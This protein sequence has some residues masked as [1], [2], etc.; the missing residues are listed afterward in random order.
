MPTSNPRISITLAPAD[1]AVLDRFAAASGTPRA[2]VLSGLVGSVLPQLQEAAELIELANAAPKRVHDELAESLSEA[3]RDAM[4]Y[5]KDFHGTYKR[6]MAIVQA[7]E[8]A[9]GRKER[10]APGPAV[11]PG[12]RP[13]P[14][15]RGVKK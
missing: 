12:S 5:L 1:L 10:A 4:G 15:N 6:S 11:L 8:Q 13:P 2:T 14:T 7:A 3:T 9:A